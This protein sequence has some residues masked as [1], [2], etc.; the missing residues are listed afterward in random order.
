MIQCLDK[1]LKGKIKEAA[2]DLY[3]LIAIPVLFI[4][5]LIHEVGHFV[6]A[7]LMKV[8][9]EEF[10][11]GF[12]PRMLVLGERN[13]V[14]YTLNWIPIG[15]FVKMAGEEDPDVPG[16][17][18]SKKPWQRIFVLTAGALMNL[19]L[20]FILFTG[21]ALYGHTEIVSQ[22]I[23]AY[24]VEASSPAERADIQP[25]DWIV[26]AN[27][28][29]IHSQ[30]DILIETTLSRGVTITMVLDRQG[31]PV[32]TTLRPRK[33]G[34][35]PKDQQGPIG[36]RLVYY[37]SPVTIQYLSPGSP[38]ETAGL[39]VGDVITAIDG[40]PVT[41]SM[42]YVVYADTHMSQTLT[43]SVRRDGQDLPPIQVSNTIAYES[44]PMGIDYL[45]LGYVTY[46]L[47]QALA[48]GVQETVDATVLIPRTLAS[49]VRGS[50]PLSDMSGIVGIT[51]TAAQVV[52]TAGLYGLLRLMAIISVNL[53][54][55][56]LFPLPALDGGRIAFVLLEWIR[57]G[58]RI[59]PE[60]EG[61]VH[62][63]GFIL[64]LAF[65]A[66]ITYYDIARW[67]SMSGGS[68]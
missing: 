41:D 47:G 32:T 1:C 59:S 25:G 21:L 33:E 24:R 62:M 6:A 36:I 64:L 57:G 56:N 8:R 45:H 35:Y 53:F 43:L 28:R 5:I 38:A 30:S 50:V 63:I 46:S 13:G 44:W 22:R 51:Y 10:G 68:P 52:R 7:R 2:L 27:G 3:W 17:L 65:V 16:S 49:L 4:L 31:Q 26:S 39:R 12:P 55:V 37:E 54:L 58:R 11:I 42:D 34:E 18:A 9:I 15:G 19:L 48:E 67:I 20:A 40:Q 60:K 66:I 14:K 29:P 23:G 61:L